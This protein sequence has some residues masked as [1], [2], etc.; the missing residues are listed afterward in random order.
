MCREGQCAAEKRGKHFFRF[1]ED[2]AVQLFK[3]IEGLI[4]ELFTT[5]MAEECHAKSIGPMKE[6]IPT[7]PSGGSSGPSRGGAPPENFKISKPK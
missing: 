3:G 1:Q 7:L 2:L 4:Q 6:V 5:Q